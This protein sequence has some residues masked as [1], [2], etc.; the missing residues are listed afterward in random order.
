MLAVQ[1]CLG[2]LQQ[3]RTERACQLAVV[4]GMW[5]CTQNL[6]AMHKI[7]IIYVYVR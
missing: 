4:P 7:D 6:V 2:R 1:R 5:R 3:S